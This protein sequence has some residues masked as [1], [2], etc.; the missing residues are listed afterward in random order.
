MKGDYM[1]SKVLKTRFCPTCKNIGYIFEQVE[2]NYTGK[3]FVE[4][5]PECNYEIVILPYLVQNCLRQSSLKAKF[6]F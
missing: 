3:M 1:T 6:S 5:C 4:E 2:A